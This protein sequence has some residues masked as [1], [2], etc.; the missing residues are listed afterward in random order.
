MPFIGV[1]V[2]Y[3]YKNERRDMRSNIPLPLKEFPRA[4]PEGTP[5][6]K[7]VYNDG[8]SKSSPHTDS[9]TF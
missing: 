8:I 3:P 5:E 7:G 2:L 9:K 4:K 1:T 6:C